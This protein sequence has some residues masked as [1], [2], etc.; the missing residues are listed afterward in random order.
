M[1]N[2]IILSC[3]IFLCLILGGCTEPG[4]L[5]LELQDPADQILINNDTYTSIYF[6]TEREDSLRNNS[7]VNLL[8]ETNSD[9]FPKNT[10]AFLTHVLLTENNISLEDDLIVDSV[11]LSYTYSDYFGTLID[12]FSE[13]YVKEI[14]IGINKDSIYY[15]NN[16]SISDFESLGDIAIDH[17]ISKDNDNPFLKIFLS[18]DFGEKILK[19]DSDDLQDNSSF[20]EKIKGLFVYAEAENTVLYLNPSGSNSVM[21]IYYRNGL[22]SSFT[23]E[24]QLDGDAARINI[25][26][27]ETDDNIINDKQYIHI[28]SM[29]GYK[30]KI[31]ILNIDSIKQMLSGKTIN[32]ATLTFN[33]KEDYQNLSDSSAHS[34]LFLGRVDLDGNILDLPDLLL[35]GETFFNGR[36]EENSFQFNITRYM[37]QLINNSS[38]TSDLYLLDKD[39]NINAKKSVLSNDISLAIFYSEL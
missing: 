30:S 12:K 4:T 17:F 37:Y 6:Q 35:E 21:N 39:A 15:S 1:K 25:F 11:V 38:Y 34:S 28:E 16:F 27:N 9:V 33:L 3:F 31:T 5:G 18:E 29:A 13:L 2:N 22:D 14:D 10:A 24:F 19:L 23:L 8:G 7:A 20:I 36:L 26:E 32:K